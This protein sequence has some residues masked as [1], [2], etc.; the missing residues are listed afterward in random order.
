MFHSELK[1]LSQVSS[2]WAKIRKNCIFIVSIFSNWQYVSEN[3]VIVEKI[4]LEISTCLHVF[5]TPE[6]A[7]ILSGLLS[8]C[9]SVCMY[10]ISVYAFACRWRLNVWTDIINIRNLRVY[11]Q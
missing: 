11:P 7:K 5:S 10:C 2:Q 1:E 3:F 9:L 6:C 8:V 4:D